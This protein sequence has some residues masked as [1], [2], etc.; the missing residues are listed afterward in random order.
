MVEIL[1]SDSA[2]GSLKMAQRYGEGDYCKG[3]GGVVIMGV[4]GGKP[5]HRELKNAQHEAEERERKAWERA[6][7]LGGNPADIFGVCHVLDIGDVSEDE[8][9]PKRQQV[10]EE[11]WRIYPE[12]VQAAKEL[13]E[14]EVKN[15]KTV[16]QR[17]LAGEALRI[18]YG[19]SPDEVC[20]LHWMM[21]WLERQDIRCTVS[22]IKIPE[23]D[24]EEDNTAIEKRSCA[25][26]EPA[27][28]HRYL[29]LQQTASPRLRSRLAAHWRNL[30][31]ENAPL[32]AV[33]NGRLMSV[34]AA[35]YDAFVFREIEAEDEVFLEARVI[36]NV[37]GKHRLG[38]GDAW[39][40]ARVEEM[41]RNGL[42]EPVNTAAKDSP[43]YHRMLR[44]C[45]KLMSDSD[46][47]NE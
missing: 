5:T 14:N 20:G 28:W 6:E 4:D 33:V 11:L 35:F 7:P 13:S 32:R 42:L 17:L 47:K 8:P 30:Q 3:A 44:K 2:C 18:W 1:F 21:A 22:L 38:I 37:L 45:G 46:M 10:L 41:I 24:M 36:G 19:S 26:C 39:I 34:P 29:A 23:L 16:R 9:G 15:M 27:D 40:A 43:T 25:E 12:G 31:K